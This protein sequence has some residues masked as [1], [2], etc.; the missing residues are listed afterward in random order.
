M[1]QN[2]FLEDAVYTDKILHFI[3]G[4]NIAR[5]RVIRLKNS[6]IDALKNHHYPRKINELLGHTAALGM[7]LTS[8]VKEEGLFTLQLQ[9]QEEAAMRLIV[10]EMTGHNSY[11]LT[12]RFDENQNKA[13]EKSENLTDLFGPNGLMVFTSD[14]SKGERYQGVAALNKTSLAEAATEWLATSDQVESWLDLRT[15]TDETDKQG[16]M[17]FGLLIQPLATQD[18]SLEEQEKNREEWQKIN[19]FAESLKNE[20]ALNEN[21]SLQDVLYRLFN[22]IGVKLTHVD[23]A[24]FACRCAKD[25]F[26]SSILNMKNENLSEL[27]T[28]GIIGI[29]CEYCGQ[30][31]HIHLDE[32]A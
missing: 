25:K 7:L 18:L 1:Q 9:A 20:E 16:H 23:E 8:S 28:N 10:A 6:Y 29:T 4:D 15:A 11:R 30:N 22:E 32:L 3:L 12:A 24:V 14:L 17:A 5:G 13:I 26:K 19:L 21:L 27:A 2:H 31:Y